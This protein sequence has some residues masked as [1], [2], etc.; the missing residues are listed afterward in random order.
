MSL[1][2]NSPHFLI[3]E[4][5]HF[6]YVF[7]ELQPITTHGY[8]IFHEDATTLRENEQPIPQSMHNN[9]HLHR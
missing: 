3:K 8:I 6:F 1:G 2:S 7:R 5:I 9:C 4:T